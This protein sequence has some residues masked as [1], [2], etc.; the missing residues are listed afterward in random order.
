MRHTVPILNL[1]FDQT[2]VLDCA[3]GYRGC[4]TCYS[5]SEETM[6]T[7]W[8]CSKP[9]QSSSYLRSDWYIGLC[10]RFSVVDARHGNA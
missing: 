1:A 5:R 8:I 4:L 3:A 6:R 2:G 10:G 7:F 9:S